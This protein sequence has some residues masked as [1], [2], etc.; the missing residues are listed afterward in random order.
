MSLLTI[1][2]VRR[3]ARLVERNATVFRRNWIVFVV[4]LTE[5]IFYLFS[6]GIGLGGLIGAVDGVDYR[7]FVAPGLLAASAMNGA[8]LDATFN[9]FFKLKYAKT[10][11]AI[12]ATPLG[13]KE[14]AL[15]DITWAQIRGTAYG[16]VFLATM[17]AL[18]LVQSWWAL[19]ALPAATLIGLSFGAVG[20][21][22]TTYMRSWQDFDFVTLA[23]LPLFLFSATFFPLSTYPGALQP[24]IAVTPLYQGV[25]LLRHLCLGTVGPVDLLHVAYLLAM[26]VAGVAVAG[27]RLGVLLRP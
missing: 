11:D 17:L 6:I 2:Q 10:Y 20:M 14:L 15:G 3:S 4:G 1:A 9:V 25:A 26:G 12:L 24:V 21:A 27:R 7:T 13:P 18:G 16:A 23:V 8:V 22:A 19:L 5:P